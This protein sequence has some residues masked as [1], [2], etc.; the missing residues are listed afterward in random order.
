[1]GDVQDMPGYA[2]NS[3]IPVGAESMSKPTESGWYWYRTNSKQPWEMREVYRD[4]DSGQIRYKGIR[5]A[6]WRGEWVRIHEP[7][8]EESK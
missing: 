6:N 5:A 1:M 8:S 2:V 3:R 4:F 7:E